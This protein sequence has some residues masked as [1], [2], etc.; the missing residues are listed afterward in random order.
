MKSL[1]KSVVEKDIKDEDL[2]NLLDAK[3]V[4]VKIYMGNKLIREGLFFRVDYFDPK[5]ENVK[6]RS[7]YGKWKIVEEES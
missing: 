6:K 1:L 4:K 3:E 5:L 2:K 7:P